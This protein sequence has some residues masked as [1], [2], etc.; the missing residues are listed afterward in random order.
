MLFGLS[1]SMTSYDQ[2]AHTIRRLGSRLDSTFIDRGISR[3]SDTCNFTPPLKNVHYLGV[4]FPLITH[5]P[6]QHF[7]VKQ[8]PNSLQKAAVG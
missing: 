2:L 8:F 4:V 5:R 7:L 3:R 1:L 6:T